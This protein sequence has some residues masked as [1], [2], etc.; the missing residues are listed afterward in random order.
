MVKQI[1]VIPIF[2][3]SNEEIIQQD[4]DI[5]NVEEK[6]TV[7]DNIIKLEDDTTREAR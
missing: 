3:N 5:L 7:E 4:E 1:T 6:Y 2:N